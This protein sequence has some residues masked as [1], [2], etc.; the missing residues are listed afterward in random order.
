MHPHQVN[1]DQC[2]ALPGDVKACVGW[3][4]KESHLGDHFCNPELECYC[5]EE[6]DCG[7]PSVPVCSALWARYQH[8]NTGAGERARGG[9]VVVDPEPMPPP[10]RRL[11]PSHPL[12]LA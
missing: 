5:E 12:L 1:H 8:L 4:T 7:N 3:W 2:G 9:G 10:S 6:G 11:E